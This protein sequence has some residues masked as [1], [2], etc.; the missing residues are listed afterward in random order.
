MGS[1]AQWSKVI[2]FPSDYAR[3]IIN[4]NGELFVCTGGNG[5]FR[6]VDAGVSWQT[7]NNGLNSQQAK[8]TYELIGLGEAL[9]VAT[10]DGIYKSTNHGDTWQ[11]KS[12]GITIGPGATFEFTESIFE[13]NG[14]LF[15]G[16]WNGL[17]RSSDGGE[18]W[19][20]TNISGEAVLA[21]NFVEHN[22]ILFA[23]RE[24]NNQ[25]IGYKSTDA[26]INWQPLEGISYFNVITFFSEPPGLWAGTIAGVWL[27]TDDG[28]NW[29]DRSNG[30][31]SDPYSSSIIRVNGVLVTSLKFGG[32]GMYRSFDDGLNWENFSDG[33]PF[34]ASI[35]KLIL[36]NDNILAATSE[37]L[38]QRDIS[39]L[40]V[41]LASFNASVSGNDVILSWT[42][43]TEKNN[44]GF[45]VQRKNNAERTTG[46]EWKDLGFVTGNGTVTE[47]KSYSFTDENI[48]G[49]TYSYRLRQV[50]YD[51]SFEYSPSV[52]V[53]VHKSEEY[54][55]SQNYPNPFNPST[56]IE[57]NI[58]AKGNVKLK[59]YDVLGNE[60]K[61]FVEQDVPAGTRQ[62]IFNAAGLS[63]GV[64]YYQIVAGSFAE[65]KQMLLVK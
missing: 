12:N 17:Y 5:V 24:V 59:I 54:Q 41:E 62:I 26:G 43:A 33:L 64:Y 19:G 57:Y 2:S 14:T 7:V 38:Y 6:S 45:E 47:F 49:G 9:Y 4:S 10:T 61:T 58:P 21:K 20:I 52:E 30:L 60:I 35:E 28:L 56:V 37:G 3:N 48:S 50:D 36:F 29:E 65:T 22:G 53:V 18:N 23:A 15:S 31:T 46:T 25:P 32:S 42:T 1:F 16:A 44:S 13:Y 63:S 27:S 34:L 51:G 40:P 55:L 8:D 39:G 11:K